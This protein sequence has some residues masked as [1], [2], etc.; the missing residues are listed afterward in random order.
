MSTELRELWNEL[1]AS[2]RFREEFVAAHAKQIIPIQLEELMLAQSLKQTELA[3]RSGLSQ[4]T[5]SRAMDPEY[6]SLTINTC[7]RLAAGLD[8][9][10]VPHFVPFSELVEWLDEIDSRVRVPKFTEESAPDEDSLNEAA[11]TLVVVK[12]EVVAL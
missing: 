8:V 5:V 10:F 2:K 1:A 4:G 3:E 9:A 12:F 11:S 7:V 6:G